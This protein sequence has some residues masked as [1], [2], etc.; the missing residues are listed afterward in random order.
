MLTA[1]VFLE[2]RVIQ[3]ERSRIPAKPP[4]RDPA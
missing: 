3:F 1:A 2:D 4:A